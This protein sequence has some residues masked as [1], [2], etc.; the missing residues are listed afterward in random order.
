MSS[1][2]R[3]DPQGGT[4]KQGEGSRAEPI[5]R[6]NQAIAGSRAEIARS[7]TLGWSEADLARPFDGISKGENDHSLE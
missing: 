7:R 3:S 6:A 2:D 4:P 1:P 5:D